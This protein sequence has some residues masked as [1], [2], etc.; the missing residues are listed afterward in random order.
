MAERIFI[1]GDDNLI[2]Y[3][4]HTTQIAAAR[5]TEEE[6]FSHIPTCQLA[7]KIIE[8]RKGRA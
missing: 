2:V 3:S 6:L 5:L 8:L 1:Q 7:L 4:D